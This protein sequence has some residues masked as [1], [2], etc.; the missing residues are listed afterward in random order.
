[1]SR[2]NRKL[3]LYLLGTALVALPGCASKVLV[4]PRVDLGLHDR[5]ALVSFTS[6]AKPGVERLV[7]QRFLETVQWAQPQA[8]ILELGPERR[9]LDLV[10][11]DHLDFEAI[12]AIGRRYHVD[13]VITGRLDVTQAKPN[14][15]LTT[16]I[17]SLS[18]SANVEGTLVAKILETETGATI[19]SGTSQGAES[20]AHLNVISHGPADFGAGNAESAYGRLVEGLVSRITTDFRPR[21][22]RE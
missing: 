13:A 7:T 14:L 17:K 12:Q 19:W 11:R 21:W 1:M 8:R 5:I 6:N 9:V 4:P 20:V 10:D 18:V 2:M 15:R 3:W 16:A 22:V